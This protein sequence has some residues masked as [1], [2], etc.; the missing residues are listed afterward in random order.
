MRAFILI[1]LLGIVACSPAAEQPSTA[2]A[3]AE[4]KPLAPPTVEEAAALIRDS[5]EFSDYHFTFS[6]ISLP[7]EKK[8]M[9]EPALRN[10]EELAAAGWLEF[11][12]SGA[13]TVPP[14]ALETRRF[15]VRPNGFLDIVPLA[16]KEFVAVT[17]VK[18]LPDGNVS[19]EFDWKWQPNEVGQ[20]LESG[21]TRERF[22]KPQRARATLMPTKSGKWS[23]LIIEEIKVVS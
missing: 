7:L 20:A 12:P 11:E 18:P 9:N 8:L 15:V 21:L 2:T 14:K 13:V 3:A 4:T 22:D 6:S 5:Q 1:L 23:V 19:A 16:R 10:A 17:A